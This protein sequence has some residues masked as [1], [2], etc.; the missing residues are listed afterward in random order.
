MMALFVYPCA[1]AVEHGIPYGTS[2]EINLDSPDYE[3]VY[4]TFLARIQ[5]SKLSGGMDPLKITV[6][7]QLVTA[8]QLVNKDLHFTIQDGR[9]FTY[10]NPDY[11]CWRLFYSP[12]FFSNNVANNP[13]R[14]MQGDACEYT[15]DITGMVNRDETN[16]IVLQHAA[17][18]WIYNCDNA[19][20][21]NTIKS[22][23]LI[24][25]DLE[26]Q[27]IGN[28]IATPAPAE[29]KPLV[30]ADL[31]KSV[32]PQTIKQDQIVTVT[33]IIRNSGQTT[34]SDIEI[35]DTVPADFILVNGDTQ[36][37]YSSLKS[38]ETRSIQYTARSTGAGTFI[39]DAAT[40]RFAD[41]SGNYQTISS[42]T[43]SVEVLTPLTDLPIATESPGFE[44]CA[45]IIGIIA[46]MAILMKRP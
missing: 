2:Y 9:S 24:V 7:D 28:P 19:R 10:Y 43:P 41:Q 5:W 39:L 27:G 14:V 29:M 45:A 46:M 42:N 22:T 15:F 35:V 6:N 16:S 11:S 26:L 1:A 30:G 33:V 4:L 18:E 34:L 3:K 23:T 37:A 17:N 25:K 36:A 31:S 44:G 12:D 40:G 32:N 20:D 8:S 38:G 13:Y 21:A